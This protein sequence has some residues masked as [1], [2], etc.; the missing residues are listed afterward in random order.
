M[1]T[2]T[3]H[4][5]VGGLPL[6]GTTHLSLGPRHP[7]ESGLLGLNLDLFQNTVQRARVQPGYLHRGA[8]K[9]FEV[10]DYRSAIMLAD[11]HDWLS[12]F[13]GEL[14]VTHAIEDA[15]GLRPPVR[16]VWLRA[17][18]AEYARIHSHL[19]YLSYIHDAVWP[20]V[21]R[22]RTGLLDWSGNRVHP[23]LN[24]V[25]GLASDVPDGWLQHQMGLMDPLLH[26]ADEVETRLGRRF[27]GL[28]VAD[29]DTCLRYSLSGPVAR[30]C[31]LE[32]DRRRN[33]SEAYAEV[34]LPTPLREAGDA[35]ARFMVLID[36]VR[37]SADMVRQLAGMV[38]D[39]PVSVKLS[40]RL[41]VPE[42][43]HVSDIEAPWGMAGALLVSRAGQTPWRLA[44]RTPTFA[45]VNALEHLLVGAQT[46]E[47]PDVIASIGFAIGDLDK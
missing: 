3:A 6:P 28:A 37:T 33:H 47:I 26:C 36:E 40:R 45:N 46:G 8:E 22:L 43:E 5:S 44:L 15:M 35:H 9:L 4:Y 32:M 29:R 12:S 1:I 10:R 41:K 24:R 23:M 34:F 16:A 38:P 2:T 14:V 25:G 31:G 18:L 20:M 7:S 11:R 42:G 13:S 39:G 19:S 27:R 17:L 21:E 30:A